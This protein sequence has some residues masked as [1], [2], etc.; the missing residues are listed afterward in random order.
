MEEKKEKQKYE[1]DNKEKIILRDYLAL[2]RTRLANERTVF[3]YIRTS[4]YLLLGGIAFLQLEDF[5]RLKWLA[6]LALIF[7]V[8]LLLIG[9]L[10]YYQLKKKLKTYYSDKQ[11]KDDRDDQNR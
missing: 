11:E 1:F 2:E 10:R 5:G 4:L 7:S 3:A 9:I 8:L 6:L